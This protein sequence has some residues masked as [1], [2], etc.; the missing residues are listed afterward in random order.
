MKIDD[1]TNNKMATD[2]ASHMMHTT[3]N[4]ATKSLFLTWFSGGLNFQI[5]H[6]LFPNICHI[7]YK[8]ISSIV[9][10]TALEFNLPYHHHNTFAR[11]LKSHFVLLNDLGTGKYDTDQLVSTSS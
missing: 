2:W 9:K 5:E 1:V 4:I 7:H 11:A 6:H 3:A 10:A 8:N